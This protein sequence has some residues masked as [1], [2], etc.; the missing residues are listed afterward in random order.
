MIGNVTNSLVFMSQ[1]QMSKSNPTVATA[2]WSLAV[3]SQISGSRGVRISRIGML[4]I[5]ERNI[6]FIIL[7][8]MAENEMKYLYSFKSQ[9]PTIQKKNLAI[10]WIAEDNHVVGDMNDLWQAK[11]MWENIF[12]PHINPGTFLFIIQSFYPIA[13]Q[14]LHTKWKE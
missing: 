14:H 3:K 12:R 13:I 9:G 4:R 5:Y 7:S 11:I 1:T 10:V 6:R 2:K 8:M